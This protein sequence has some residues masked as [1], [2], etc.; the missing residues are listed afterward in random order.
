MKYIKM[1]SLAAVAAMALMAFVGVGSASATTLCKTNV[2]PCPA[3]WDYPA[4]TVIT[5]SLVPN[6]SAVL[7]AGIANITCSESTAEIKT[8]ETSGE[9]LKGDLINLTFN[10]CNCRVSVLKP[11]TANG[12]QAPGS[13]TATGGG[14][15]SVK[16]ENGVEVE[17]ECSGVVCVYGG[18][19]TGLEVQGGNPAKLVATPEKVKIKKLSGSFLCTNPAEW[20]AEYQVTS[21]VGPLFVTK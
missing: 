15:G 3:E 18:E 4:G 5:G 16:L 9:P 1:L 10:G 13:I 12:T 14:N 7:H 17:V 8:T 20:T 11:L 2:E 6:T 19:A 21:P